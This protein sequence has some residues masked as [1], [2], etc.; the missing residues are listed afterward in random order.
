[1]LVIL[2][3]DHSFEDRRNMY[4]ADCIVLELEINV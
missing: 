4:P 1:M 2:Y 3:C